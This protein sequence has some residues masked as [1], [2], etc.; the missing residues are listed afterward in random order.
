MLIAAA[1][2]MPMLS[3]IDRACTNTS[4]EA[5]IERTMFTLYFLYPFSDLPEFSTRIYVIFYD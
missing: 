1:A 4:V 5:S 3:A 2:A